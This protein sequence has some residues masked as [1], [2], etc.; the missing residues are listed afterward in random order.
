MHPDPVEP[1]RPG[2]R[3]G[4]GLPTRLAA[5]Q[6][7]LILEW[8][9]GAEAGPFASLAVTDRVVVDALEPLGVL[10]LAAGI[11]RRIGLL[12]S[13]IIGP[14]RE[15]TLLARQ[16]STIDL[17]SGGRLTL[18]LGVGARRDDYAATGTD[19]GRR[20]RALEAQLAELRSIWRGEPASGAA[21]GAGGVIGPRPVRAGGP[22]VLIGGYVDA[23]TRRIASWGDGY[24]APGGGEPAAIAA[25]WERI[26]ARWHE[27]GRSGEP[28]FVG[29]SYVALGPD[30]DEAA[31]AYV[32]EA[33]GHDPALAERRLRGVPTTPVA[34]RALLTRLSAM[35]MDEVILRPCTAG[36]D[37]LDRIAEL[38]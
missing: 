29:G 16:A 15:T 33:Y 12:A 6:P 2:L 8:A 22:Q 31:R 18:G 5:A 37:Q 23:V 20:G 13:V 26:R 10:A 25:L 28:R 3:I 34:V 35:G 32:T 7:G 36:I 17:L 19:F 24:M 1:T 4:V 11:T 30:A 38:V 14:T 27:A 21:E 9:R